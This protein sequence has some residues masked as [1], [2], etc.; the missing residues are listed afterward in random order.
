MARSPERSRPLRV[1]R[2]ALAVALALPSAAVAFTPE[3]LHAAW[4]QV[5]FVA[6]PAPCLRHGELV[7]RLGELAERHAGE[8]RLETAGRSVQGRTIHLL[9]I[10]RGARKVLLWS[11]MHGDEPAA[12]PALLDLAD[13][14]LSNRDEP[15]AARILDELTLLIVPM[16]NPDGTEAYVRQNAQAIDVNR[17]ALAL[18][19]PE[20]RLLKALRDRHRPILGFNLH[21]QNRRRT[22][23]DSGVLATNAVLA[24]TGDEANTLTSGRLRAK[25]ACAAIA[26]ALGEFFPGGM[27]RYDEEWSPRAF[28]DNLT[29]W[30]TPVVLIESGGLPPGTPFEELTRLN[31]VALATA[32]AELARNDLADHDPA[33]YDELPANE[34]GDWFDVAVRGGAIRQPGSAAPYRADLVFDRLVG[35]RVA[36]GCDGPAE[37]WSEIGEVGDARYLHAGRDVD[38]GGAIL[39]APFRMAV[40]GYRARRWLDGA[41]LDRLARLGVVEVDWQVSRRRAEAART[42]AAGIAGPGRPR[43]HVRAEVGAPLFELRS[44]PGAPASDTL[45]DVLRALAGAGHQELV[46]GGVDAA[47]ARLW[48]EPEPLA[49]RPLLR[50]GAGAHFLIVDTADGGLDLDTARLRS[51]WIDG[52]EVA[53]A[54]P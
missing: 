32:L 52:R 18:S 42:R 23:G 27:A 26:T 17:D 43:F 29:A 33:V 54:S 6:T 1:P 37:Q 41:A 46:A 30:G 40:R 3:T 34:L 21:D 10:G 28:G 8:L 39:V 19:T 12:T 16:L 14:L 4:P 35:D 20:G 45:G 44:A 48:G 36:A 22:A 15:D 47:F 11:Q 13:Y 2:L 53:G 25:R 9:T 31:F 49:G 24:V 5:R 38:A 50:P 7:A 51:V